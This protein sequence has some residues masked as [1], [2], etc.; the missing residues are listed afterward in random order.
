MSF[1]GWKISPEDCSTLLAKFPPA[2]EPVA[3]PHCTL[4]LGTHSSAPLP[5][6]AQGLIIARVDNL[7]G[8]EAFL[9]SIDGDTLR[10]DGGTFHIT[11]S[12]A[13]GRKPKE[14]NDV[15]LSA[16]PSEV[17]PPVLVDLHPVRF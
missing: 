4:A 11:W 5:P 8:V 9:V 6:P 3:T 13:A 16:P 15:I 2:Y 1:I 14:S 10:P 7:E 17:F 12:L